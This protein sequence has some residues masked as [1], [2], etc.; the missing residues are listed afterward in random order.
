[1]NT[2]MLQ[3][4]RRRERHTLYCTTDKLFHTFQIN[5]EENGFICWKRLVSK[6]KRNWIE[7]NSYL[8]LKDCMR[9]SERIS[10]NRQNI[11]QK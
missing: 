8:S 2:I 3:S 1:M 6:D 4:L 9:I 5:K 11:L 10:S 7:W